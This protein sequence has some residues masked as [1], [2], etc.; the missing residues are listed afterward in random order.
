[1]RPAAVL[2]LLALA[3]A[4][5]GA[6]PR[7]SAQ[8]FKGDE[9]AVAAV[10]ERLESAARDNEPAV[11]CS[12]LLSTR[13]LTA[14]RQQGTNC[15]TGVREGFRDADSVDL[16]V[17]DVEIRGTRATAKVEYRSRSQDRTATL[18]LDREGNAWKL[19]S[20]GAATS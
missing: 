9:R 4:G 13:L 3:V 8:D 17:D 14:L 19:S 5:C 20:L 10:V 12:R 15:A 16:T 11:V 2:C 18:Q 6:A 7:D 1:M